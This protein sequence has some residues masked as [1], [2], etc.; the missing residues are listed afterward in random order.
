MTNCWIQAK[1]E[2]TSIPILFNGE[3]AEYAPIGSKVLVIIIS[4]Q[5]PLPPMGLK[6]RLKILELLA[7]ELPKALTVFQPTVINPLL[8]FTSE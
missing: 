3:K 7:K 5:S 2:L 6:Q 1:P 4:E 8:A